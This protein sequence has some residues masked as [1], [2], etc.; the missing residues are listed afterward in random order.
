[1]LLMLFLF[2]SLSATFDNGDWYPFWSVRRSCNQDTFFHQWQ[3]YIWLKRRKVLTERVVVLCRY[4]TNAAFYNTDLPPLLTMVISICLDLVLAL[5]PK[6]C[7]ESMILVVIVGTSKLLHWKNCLYVS[8]HFCCWLLLCF[9]AATFWLWWLLFLQ[10][11]LFRQRVWHRMLHNIQ[12]MVAALS[13]QSG[14]VWKALSYFV[15]VLSIAY[16]VFVEPC[17]ATCIHWYIF[18]RQANFVR[19]WCLMCQGNSSRFCNL[20]ATL[21]QYDPCLDCRVNWK[22]QLLDIPCSNVP[23][24][25]DSLWLSAIP[26]FFVSSILCL[27][28]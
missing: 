18:Y 28:L 20:F 2:W 25:V 23:K 1:M 19:L 5:Q 15:D 22:E 4:I 14:I 6:Y 17:S 8:L 24:G 26:A 13:K 10:I 16:I 11:W 27:F 3:S 21:I 9:L 7:F 12:I